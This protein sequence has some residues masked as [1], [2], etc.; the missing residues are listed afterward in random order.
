VRVVVMARKQKKKKH[1]KKEKHLVITPII[2]EVLDFVT[3]KACLTCLVLIFFCVFLYTVTKYWSDG[4][5]RELK[6]CMHVYTTSLEFL[7]CEACLG[8]NS[9]DFEREGLANCRVARQKTMETPEQCAHRRRLENTSISKA[10]THICNL[11][12]GDVY[13]Y[14]YFPLFL[15]SVFGFSAYL[16]NEKLKHKDVLRSEE[17]RERRRHRNYERIP[18]GRIS[19]S[20]YRFQDMQQQRTIIVHASPQRMLQAAPTRASAQIEEV[21]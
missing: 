19:D 20:P 6:D 11:A 16:V 9:V 17:R 21:D 12:G 15:L 2:N 1:T 10:I 5:E 3:V 14:V 18:R 8:D 4:Y 7:H 13:G